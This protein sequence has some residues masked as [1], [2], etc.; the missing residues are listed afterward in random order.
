MSRCKGCRKLREE[1]RLFP[2]RE[3]S[4]ES[5]CGE[6][7][8]VIPRGAFKTRCVNCDEFDYCAKC[9]RKCPC[10]I[11]P[12]HW[13]C[14]AYDDYQDNRHTCM[15]YKGRGLDQPETC[16]IPV[17]ANCRVPDFNPYSEGNPRFCN[18]HR[19]RV[20]EE[21][22]D[23]IVQEFMRMDKKFKQDVIEKLTEK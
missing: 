15:W 3:C 11:G 21:N 19:K 5:Y 23:A 9:V 20:I 1:S 16:N 13:I 6:S 8:H 22:C 12:D 2:C 17:C 4:D 7:N 18:E 10:G 14:K